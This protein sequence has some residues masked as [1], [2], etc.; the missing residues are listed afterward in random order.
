M[1]SIG[2]GMIYRAFVD[3]TII[4]FVA[5]VDDNER[6]VS[7][8][9]DT[10]GAKDSHQ[11]EVICVWRSSDGW[12]LV[13]DGHVIRGRL[14]NC[15]THKVAWFISKRKCCRDWIWAGL[16]GRIKGIKTPWK[17]DRESGS[18]T[19]KF[20]RATWPFFKFDKLPGSCEKGEKI[21]CIGFLS[22]NDVQ[23]KMAYNPVQ[24]DN[25][26]GSDLS[27]QQWTMEWYTANIWQT[28]S[29]QIRA[30]LVVFWFFFVG[31]CPP[32]LPR[33]LGLDPLGLDPLQCVEYQPLRETGRI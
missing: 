3:S 17:D 15:K 7:D 8:V 28:N 10:N 19:L 21:D 22:L 20:N 4:G 6:R 24:R 9:S 2:R 31:R 33:R 16:T 1:W 32:P 5:L 13:D 30:Y 29:V 12:W 14:S 23:T 25:S 11:P 27:P 18:R 26:G